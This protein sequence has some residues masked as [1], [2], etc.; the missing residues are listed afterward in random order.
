MTTIKF[1]AQQ[2]KRLK[3]QA[4]EVRHPAIGSI[5][6]VAGAFY[7]KTLQLKNGNSEVFEAIKASFSLP[8]MSDFGVLSMRVT[9]GSAAQHVKQKLKMID[10]YNFANPNTQSTE[11]VYYEFLDGIEVNSFEMWVR[12]VELNDRDVAILATDDNPFEINVAEIATSERF[13]ALAV[14]S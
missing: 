6:Y 12:S 14:L 2:Q 9:M 13:P 7:N 4:F 3:H 10:D 1:H 8:N 5:R 11:F